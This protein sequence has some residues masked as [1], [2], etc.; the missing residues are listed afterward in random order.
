MI[1]SIPPGENM[2]LSTL[3]GLILIDVVLGLAVLGLATV[4]YLP[5]LGLMLLFVGFGSNV[6]GCTG[7]PEARILLHDA[8][9]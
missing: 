2:P 1:V 9:S 4:L 5:C 8:A 7:H 3:R 6:I